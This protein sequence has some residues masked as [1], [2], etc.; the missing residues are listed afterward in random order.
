MLDPQQQQCGPEQIDEL[1]RHEKCAERYAWSRVLCSEAYAEMSDEHDVRVVEFAACNRIVFLFN[2]S[3]MRTR[4]GQVPL[5]PYSC[6][7]IIPTCSVVVNLRS[8][9]VLSGVPAVRMDK[10]AAR[11]TT[12]HQITHDRE[13]WMSRSPEERLQAVEF[14]RQQ[15]IQAQYDSEPRLQRVYRLVKRTPR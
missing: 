3:V 9:K 1:R 4:Y 7:S 2:K 12:L 5:K 15:Y 6:M 11:I 13:Y 14:L 8:C 10:S